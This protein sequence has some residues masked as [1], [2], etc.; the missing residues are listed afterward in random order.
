MSGVVMTHSANE[1]EMLAQKAA[2]GAGAYPAQA[3]HFGKAVVVH[4]SEDRPVG[5]LLDALDA[6]PEGPIQI[7]PILAKLNET[8]P[9][10][11]SYAALRG[12]DPVPVL[13]RL[14]C[15]HVLFDALTTYAMNTYV[16]ATEESRAGAGAGLTD[17]D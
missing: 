4:L 5:L 3:A 13:D 16:P 17:S 2:R 9:L 15:P 7:L 8:E 6:L 11:K 12:P 10:Q 14:A 1:V